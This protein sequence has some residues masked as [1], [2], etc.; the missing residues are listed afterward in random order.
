[1]GGKHGRALRGKK[2]PLNMGK[3]KNHRHVIET[4]TKLSGVV[5]E[6]CIAPKCRKHNRK[7]LV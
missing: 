7:V 5:F 3:E 1:M 6:R 2:T 4:F